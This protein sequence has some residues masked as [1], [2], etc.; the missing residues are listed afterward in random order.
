MKWI[1]TIL[2]KK[3]CVWKYQKSLLSGVTSILSDHGVISIIPQP[4]H[5]VRTTLYERHRYNVVLTSCVGW[6]GYRKWREIKLRNRKIEIG[7][8]QAWASQSLF[9][10]ESLLSFAKSLTTNYES[11]SFS[12]NLWC[13]K[14]KRNIV[15]FTLF[16]SHFEWT[17][18][19]WF[20]LGE[21]L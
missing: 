17:A 16:Y 2:I 9:N 5:D 4:A 20:T 11:Y 1:Y 8:E 15:Y 19:T 18:H 14:R 7:C 21:P 10:I 6:E 12:R 3:K 13:S